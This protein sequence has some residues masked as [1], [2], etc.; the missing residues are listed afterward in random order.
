VNSS[1]LANATAGQNFS[2][3]VCQDGTGGHAFA[4]PANVQWSAIGSN[5]AGSCVAESFAFD[6]ATAYYL[7]PVAYS[8]G[9]AINNLTG[10]GLVLEV[11]GETLA[12]P[13]AAGVVTFPFRMYSGQ[14]YLAQ[15]AQQPTTP[16]QTCTLTTSTGSVAASNVILPVN[17]IGPAG[18]PI[19]VTATATAW[20]QVLV[21]W[22]PP[23][24]NG[25]AP[26]T[27]YTVQDNYGD[28]TTASPT[29]TSAPLG[30]TPGTSCHSG[31]LV[32]GYGFP[33]TGATLSVTPQSF[34]FTVTANNS[35]GSGAVSTPSNILSNPGPYTN[36]SVTQ[37]S[38][39]CPDSNHNYI[40]CIFRVTFTPP[41]TAGA[42]SLIDY[43]VENG[44]CTGTSFSASQS[45]PYTVDY[46]SFSC[47]APYLAPF[48]WS[49][50]TLG[51]LASGQ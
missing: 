5:L 47:N 14:P 28:S 38:S 51:L 19:N 20:G 23:T 31:M 4:P 13:S 46:S 15:I 17:C 40:D 33:C 18:A 49:Q 24:S 45:Q 35:Y 32:H 25:G 27:G 34:A 26:L 2:L 10:S 50:N 39:S 6:G 9:G 11:N 12:V 7:G 44:A 43:I 29:A 16:S 30:V 3:I 21:S 8:V 41:T 42:G 36:G 48:V 22:T 1:T 37:T